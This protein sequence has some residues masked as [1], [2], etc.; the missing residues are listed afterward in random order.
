MPTHEHAARLT[1][2]CVAAKQPPGI[3]S[4]KGPEGN[5]F[6]CTLHSHGSCKAQLPGIGSIGPD[7][8]RLACARNGMHSSPA[9]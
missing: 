5:G 3:G 8:A 7:A 1:C 6:A 9:E 2:T 4:L